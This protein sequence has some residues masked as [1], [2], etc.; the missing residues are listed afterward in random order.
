VHRVLRRQLSKLGVD[1]AAGPS[2]PEQ[3]QELMERIDRS[4]QQADQDRYTLE[5]SL[6]LSSQEMQDLYRRQ[7]ESSESRLRAERDKLRSANAHLQALYEGSPDMIFLHGQDGRLLDVNDQ[8]LQVFGYTRQEMLEADLGALMG[9]GFTGDMAM[10]RIQ[11]AFDGER[12]E[13]EWVGRRKSGEEFP[14]EVRLRRLGS[15]SGSHQVLAVVRDIAERKRAEEALRLAAT[16]FETQEGILIADGNG[17][18]L[19]VNQAFTRITGYGLEEIVG[20]NPRLLQSGRQ[21]ADFYRRMWES[22]LQ[23][24]HWEGE[25]WNRRKNGEVYP[26]WLSI[27]AVRDDRAQISHYVAAFVDLSHVRAQQTFIERTAAEEQALSHL[28][29]LSLQPMPV[30]PYLQQALDDLIDSVPWLGFLPNGGMFLAEQRDGEKGLRLVAA[31][32]LAPALHEACAWVPFGKCLCG[33][34]AMERRVQSAHCVDERHDI[35]YESMPPHGHYNVP[36]LAGD[37]VLGVMVVYLP[38]GHVDVEHEKGFLERVADVLG[39]GIMRRRAEAEIEYRAYHDALTGLPNRRLLVDRLER[40]LASFL[41]HG[42]KGAVLFIDLDHFKTVNDSLGHPTGDQLLRLVA[43]RLRHLLRKEDTVARLGGDEFVVLLPDISDDPDVTANHVRQVADKIRAALSR[44]YRLDEHEL[45]VTPSIGIA[46]FPLGQERADDVLRQADTAMYRAK[47]GG[48]NTAQF[49]LPDMQTAV[50]ERLH[51]QNDLR[52]ALAREELSLHFQTQVDASGRVVGAE[53]LL[54]WQR[55]NSGP[56]SPA[57]FIPLAEETGLILPIGE[58]VLREACG[59]F[60]QWFEAGLAGSLRH[61]A[62][63]V[64]P[65]QFHQP[66]FVRLVERVLMETDMPADRLVLE[67]TEGVVLNKAAETVEKMQ[68]IK[69]L[70]VSFSMD[71]FG[72]GYSSLAYLQRLPLNIL[73]IDR[74]FVR[75]VTVTPGNAAIVEAIIAMARHLSLQVIAEGVETADELRFLKQKGCDAFQGFYF[76]RP[77]PA[78]EFLKLLRLAAKEHELQATTRS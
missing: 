59:L 1:A 48:R 66:E 50:E 14:I 3:W 28:L 54:R 57:L 18:I 46:L 26:Q 21:D 47:E 68:A 37:D 63:N 69:D 42:H 35:R 39:I 31:R 70:G 4:Y 15:G 52:G 13:F 33:R 23:E 43:S 38:D 6:T 12:L 51:V 77:V 74:S 32:G 62:V 29:R 72:T 73:K 22:L 30:N 17:K 2:R 20:Q 9:A 40:S 64:S 61:L 44:P 7:R 56:L 8:T 67:L 10:A 75:D 53:A 16:A 36:I 19:K 24:G 27:T 58:W 60:R 45:H 49:F 41:R 5:R 71:D 55:Q 34:A 11:R 65:R 78:D 76:N 25:I